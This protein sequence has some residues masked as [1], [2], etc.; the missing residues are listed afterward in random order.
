MSDELTEAERAVAEVL[1]S[2]VFD[3]EMTLVN[4]TARED[5]ARAVMAAV[6]PIIEAETSRLIADLI[7]DNQ[8]LQDALDNARAEARKMMNE[9]GQSWNSISGRR[10]MEAIDNP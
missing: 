9:H 2:A 8:G 6:R 7:R 5:I 3:S 10:I 1:D 4:D